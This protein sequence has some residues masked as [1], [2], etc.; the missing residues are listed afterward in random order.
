MKKLGKLLKTIRIERGELLFDM[1]QRLHVSSAFLSA[2]ENDKRSAPASWIDILTAEYNLSPIQQHELTE[3]VN[4]SIKQ[5]RLDVSSVSPNKR[6][7]ALAFARNF[8]DF[9]DDEIREILSV[10]GRRRS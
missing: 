4:E 9:T 5:V 7:C 8:D 6:N 2:V 3:A 1:A 10:M